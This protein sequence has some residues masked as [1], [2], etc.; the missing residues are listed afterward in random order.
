M[1]TMGFEPAIPASEG[2][3]THVI[4]RGPLGSPNY[5]HQSN[6]GGEYIWAREMQNIKDTIVKK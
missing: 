2:L 1:P 5:H 4:D 6:E 3:Q